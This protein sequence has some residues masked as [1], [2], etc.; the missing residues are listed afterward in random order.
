MPEMD[1]PGEGYVGRRRCLEFGT[2][3][4]GVDVGRK[5]CWER[6][7]LHDNDKGRGACHSRAMLR[8]EECWVE[9]MPGRGG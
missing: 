2:P 3:G 4:E 6:G 7:I 9:G 1:I 8:R 5:G